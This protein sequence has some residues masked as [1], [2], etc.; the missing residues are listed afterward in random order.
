MENQSVMK[1]YENIK[2]THPDKLIFFRLGDFFELF[3]NDAAIAAQI[4]GLA[5]TRRGG[6]DMCG[7]P[8]SAC[9]NYA[10][11][12]ARAGHRVAICDQIGEKPPSGLMERRI[13]Q[14]ITPAMAEY[15]EANGEILQN[16]CIVAV[17]R[18][19]GYGLA[20]C[21]AICGDFWVMSHKNLSH[22]MEEITK[23]NPV[24]IIVNDKFIDENQQTLKIQPVC[25]NPPACPN[26]FLCKHFGLANLAAF[27]LKPADGATFAA[28]A[29]I[30]YLQ[31]NWAQSAGHITKI[32][33]FLPNDHM[34]LDATARR[35][36]ELT[37][38]L[39][40]GEFAG[41][42]LGIIDKTKTPAGARLLRRW[43]EA[44]LRNRAEINT[45]HGAVGDLKAAREI[46]ASIRAALGKMRDMPRICGRI[47]KGR[48][49]PA[50][51]FALA[52]S[53]RQIWGI[54]DALAP[55]DSPMLVFFANEIDRMEDI[56]KFIETAISPDAPENIGTGAVFNPA[57]SPKLAALADSLNNANQQIKTMEIHEQ[58]RTG[59]K[60]LRIR[61]TQSFGYFI[62]IGSASAAAAP[63]DYI[64]RQT[65]LNS[66]RFT[67]PEL[68][69]LQDNILAT[70][71][72]I[73]I[74][75]KQIFD[76]LIVEIAGKIPRIQ[77]AAEMTASIDALQ[78]LAQ[79]ADAYNYIR[80]NFNNLGIISMLGGRHPVVEQ[81]VNFVPNDLYLDDTGK[82]ICLITGANM[83]GKSTLLRQLAHL[84]IMAQMGGFV[85]CDFFDMQICDR[86]FTRIGAS[87]D[88]A[89]GQSTFLVEMSET[90]IILNNATPHSLVI[91]D[92]IGRGTSNRDGYA[93]ALAI[94]EHLAAHTRAKT[95][96][97]THFHELGAAEIENVTS[98]HFP[99]HLI[100]GDLYFTHKLAPGTADDSFGIHAAK[101]AGIPDSVIARAAE[102]S[103]QNNIN[104]PPAQK[105]WRGMWGLRDFSATENMSEIIDELRYK[106]DGKNFFNF[107]QKAD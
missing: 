83:A 60:G 106:K 6:W 56:V 105:K 94:L 39:R 28:A 75:E 30:D 40:T 11:Q 26:D 81:Y 47:I 91:L 33:Q 102:L 64:R 13:T 73:N 27:G 107:R 42:L 85:P 76:D 18:G 5:I 35:N 1:Q 44:P 24:E 25:H 71:E 97:A 66:E 53:I 50:E 58:K 49:G 36:L 62:E 22:L 77:L 37:Q 82:L 93:I 51:L 78:S 90:A 43:L 59:I 69:Q 89:A 79:A 72:E 54:A 34:M 12:L 19:A 21:D 52:A 41:S 96:F 92:E 101:I 7:V 95:L 9:E 8:H 84:A 88:L 80:P 70:Q 15:A 17:Y 29:L 23:I 46:R 16:S 61:Q 100:D 55:L 99:A 4:L 63:N 3:D 86:I 103:R 2:N 14:I 87:D 48:A 32:S 10:M 98:F 45:R 68:S 65:L 31:K 67:T 104:D 38:T 74:L 20:I 57:H